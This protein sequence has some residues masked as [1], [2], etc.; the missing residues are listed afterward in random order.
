MRKEDAPNGNL[1]WLRHIDC[2]EITS[3]CR[4]CNCI[5]LFAHAQPT[6]LF[7]HPLLR[8]WPPS[9]GHFFARA[10]GISGRASRRSAAEYAGRLRGHRPVAV[11]DALIEDEVAFEIETP[12]AKRSR[13]AGQSPRSP[14]GDDVREEAPHDLR[15]GGKLGVAHIDH[16]DEAKR[17][18]HRTSLPSHRDPDPGR[19]VRGTIADRRPKWWVGCP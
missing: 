19:D 16:L 8:L 12:V 13:C 1:R 3:T 18:D 14:A 10:T 15:H 5:N 9:G 17:S 11:I 7:R 4:T 6:R 2:R